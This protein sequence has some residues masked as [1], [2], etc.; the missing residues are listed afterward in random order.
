MGRRS[1][2]YSAESF[3]VFF[4]VFFLLLFS[5]VAGQTLALS[6]VFH[7]IQG[8]ATKKPPKTL[9]S[10]RFCKPGEVGKGGRVEDWGGDNV[11]AAMRKL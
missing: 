11:S 3:S 1:A 10:L 8:R 5:T 4:L 2:C 7:G 6:M 9:P